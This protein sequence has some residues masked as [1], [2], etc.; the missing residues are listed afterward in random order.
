MNIQELKSKIQYH[1]DKVEYAESKLKYH[2]GEQHRLEVELASR[3]KEWA[4]IPDLV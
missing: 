1:K 4:H 2:K 3:E